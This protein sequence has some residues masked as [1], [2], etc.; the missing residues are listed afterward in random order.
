MVTNIGRILTN[1]SLQI[2][3]QGTSFDE[4]MRKLSSFVSVT[5]TLGSPSRRYYSTNE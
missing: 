1:L 2:G 3:Y 5:C 4:V